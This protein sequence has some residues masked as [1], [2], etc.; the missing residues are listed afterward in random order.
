MSGSP[1][2]LGGDFYQT[3]RAVVTEGNVA[4]FLVGVYSAQNYNDELAV[5]TRL[6]K[7][8]QVLNSLK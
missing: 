7:V 3:I 6:D 8:F 5:V 2:L 1:V 4:T